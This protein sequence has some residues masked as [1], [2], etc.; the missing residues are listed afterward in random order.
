MNTCVKL[1]ATSTVAVMLAFS[2]PAMADEHEIATADVE[3]YFEGIQQEFTEIVQTGEYQR[4]LAWGEENLGDEARF[5]MNSAL[6][7]DGQPKAMTTITVD[8]TDLG[9]GT[10]LL[11]AGFQGEDPIDDYSLQVEVV[12]VVSHGPQAA[13]VRVT[14]QETGTFS[15]GAMGGQAAG[16]PELSFEAMHACSHVVHRNGDRMMIGLTTCV[17][18]T[19]L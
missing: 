3:Q 16:N 18:E 13:T 2:G 7:H 14:W 6:L 11:L 12:E 4:M 19:R 8:K 1:A 5:H 10:R 9:R 17:G 15:P